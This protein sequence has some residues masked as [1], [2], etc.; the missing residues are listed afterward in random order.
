MKKFG[1]INRFGKKKDID[2]NH[3]SFYDGNEED[4]RSRTGM[5]G[6]GLSQNKTGQDRGQF[7]PGSDTE[8]F[9]KGA[10]FVPGR[11]TLARRAGKRVTFHQPCRNSCCWYWQFPTGRIYHFERGNYEYLK[12]FERCPSCGNTHFNG[13]TG[14]ENV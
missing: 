5:I 4:L 11:V 2:S 9:A 10:R 1:I 14:E 6:L 13:E 7:F 12:Q 3:S 8:D